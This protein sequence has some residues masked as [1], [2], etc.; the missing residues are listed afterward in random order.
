MDLALNLGKTVAEIERDMTGV[1]FL[2]WQKYAN[3]TALP[4]RRI[5]LYLAQV[6]LKISQIM[7]GNT[8]A[9]IADYMFDPDDGDEG[10]GD[11]DSP[12]AAAEFFGFAPRK[13][14]E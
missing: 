3:R 6:A 1:E 11:D 7:G 2:L 8:D 10:E 13:V 12:E 9:T 5:E 4:L 14:K